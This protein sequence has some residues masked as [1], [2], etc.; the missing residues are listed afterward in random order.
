MDGIN[1]DYNYFQQYNYNHGVYKN[2]RGKIGNEYYSFPEVVLGDQ[3]EYRYDIT[4]DCLRLNRYLKEFLSGEACKTQNC[5]QYINYLL[6]QRVHD[7][8]GSK[9]PIFK[10]Y[11]NYMNHENN[12]NEIMN[13][14]LPKINYMP[15]KKYEKIHMLYIAYKAC[16]SY[17][18]NKNRIT[19]CALAKTC[20]KAY[21][22][23]ITKYTERDDTKF[24][25]PLKNLKDF[26]KGNE[27]AQSLMCDLS[28]SGTLDYPYH[29][30]ELLK[31]EEKQDESMQTS[32]V[33]PEVQGELRE[34]SEGQRQGIP[35]VRSPG[36]TDTGTTESAGY[37][38]VGGTDREET[39]TLI[40]TQAGANDSSADSPSAN[41]PN[42]AGTIIGTSFGFFIPL[43]MLYKFTPLGNWVNTKVLGRDKLINNMKKNELEFLLNNAQ[44]QDVNSG[45]TIYRIKYNSAL[46]E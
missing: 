13:L 25:K 44:T 18:S 42:P 37:V 1:E 38:P 10:I 43:T 23:I 45:D 29:C 31:K 8:Y 20:A 32:N 3:T 16:Q 36:V 5:C 39:A 35:E 15:P 41:I 26:L 14:C 9:E 11:N 21:K 4:M 6:N 40:H 33:E 17:I 22:N 2:I 7:A 34:S 12:N 28:F 24:C 19:S 27:P 46:N 30:N